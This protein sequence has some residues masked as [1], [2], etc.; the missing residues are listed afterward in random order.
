MNEGYEMNDG[1]LLSTTTLA[2]F[3]EATRLEILEHFGVS[4]S[5]LP[6]HD[7]APR[8]APDGE[9]GPP[10]LTV[11][12]VRKLT[13]NVSDKTLS[14]LRTIAMS[15]T[16]EFHQK[17]VLAA[18]GASGYMEARGVWS[19]IT[20]RLRSIVSDSEAYLVWWEDEGIYE[21]E[22]YVDHIGRVSPMTH[23][24]LKAHFGV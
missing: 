22:D 17:D 20:R 24:S 23:Q 8:P 14:A 7:G 15:P 13:K 11:G 2:G 19:A 4:V 6:T 12:M 1:L 10:D 21:G 18:V 3:S 9:D 16:P 5:G